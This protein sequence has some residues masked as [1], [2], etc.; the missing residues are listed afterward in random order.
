MK[1]LFN[2]TILGFALLA[3]N[4]VAHAADK[5]TAEEATALVKKAIAYMNANGKDKAFAEIN[6]PKGQFTVKDMYIFVNDLHGVTLAHGGNAKLVGK[7][8]MDLKDADG[9]SFIKEMYD[10]AGK[11][12][13]GWVDYKWVNPV[14][15]AI[16]AK[17]TYIEKAGD[18]IVGAGIY[19]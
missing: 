8:V 18:V 12:G 11:K 10:V 14:T 6:E 5:A 16:D 13:K 1:I 19:K 17:S 9:K 3:F 4:P 2:S 15:K 7:N